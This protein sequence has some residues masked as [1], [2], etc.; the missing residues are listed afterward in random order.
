MNT[1]VVIEV[2]IFL[3]IGLVIY[4]WVKNNTLNRKLSESKQ[5]V[6]GLKDRYDAQSSIVRTLMS[7]MKDLG[8]YPKDTNARIN[9]NS[10]LLRMTAAKETEGITWDG[11]NVLEQVQGALKAQYAVLFDRDFLKISSKSSMELLGTFEL[12]WLDAQHLE[13]DPEVKKKVITV[14]Q[15]IIAHA[16]SYNELKSV[17]DFM[18]T[19]LKPNFSNLFEEMTPFVQD[20]AKSLSEKDLFDARKSLS[21]MI[22]LPTNTSLKDVQV[23]F[24]HLISITKRK[25]LSDQA[26]KDLKRKSFEV[27][28]MIIRQLS[29]K[30]QVTEIALV[31]AE[32]VAIFETE[33]SD[34]KEIVMATA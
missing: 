11:K 27:C 8:V 26:Q 31:N 34:I 28:K 12:K 2:V 29:G 13:S 10:L 16:E 23:R 19:W 33:F 1:L 6:Q 25:L 30:S 3:L 22:P 17:V 18:S 20:K 21:E 9:L 14:L 15:Y 4:L 5:E 32:L 24:V 7:V